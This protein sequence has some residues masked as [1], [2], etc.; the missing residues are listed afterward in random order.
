[1]G[2]KMK[3]A[4]MGTG[5]LGGYYGGLLAQNGND[6]TFIARGAHLD[7]IRNK[8]L[9]VRSA[10]GDFVIQPARATSDP[11]QVGPVDWVLFTVKTY[12]TDAAIQAM[13]PLVGEA[14]T[15]LTMQNG[16][17]SFDRLAA[18][19]G[20]EK[21]LVTPTQITTAIAEPG[22]IVQD[23][24]FRNM[25][26][27]EMDQRVTPRVEWLVDQFKRHGVNVSASDQMPTPVWMKWIFLAPVAGL[28][29]LART[30]GAVLFRSELAQETLRGA[31]QECCRIAHAR[32]VPLPEDAADKQFN[33]SMGLKPGNLAS[34]HRDLLAGR[35]LELDALNG[36]VVR[37][38]SALGV[39]T[40]IHQTIY[41]A[42][43][44]HSNPGKAS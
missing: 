2:V 20:K 24:A 4:V 21:V 39:S 8:G 42:L 32:G 7:A 5:G 31:I 3:I 13:R 27:G 30:E 34:M 43:E 44:P 12:D 28:T 25:T 26:V 40:P 6:V 38:G 35:R 36:A 16:I 10:N 22:V 14:T 37:L 41:V 23:S 9:T 18:A 29:T 19:F 11:A 33:F 15:V 17:E 1:M